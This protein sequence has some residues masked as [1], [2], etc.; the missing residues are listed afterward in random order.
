MAIVGEANILVKAITTG[1][2]ADLKRQL[3]GMSG[4]I[5]A[6]GRRSGESLGQAFSRGFRQS[7]ASNV[8]TQL[9]NGIRA[10]VPDAE[11]ARLQ[12]RSLVRVGY[13][14]STAL[15]TIIGGL[16]AL[17]GGLI[18]LVGAIGRAL[19]AVAGLASAFIQMRV[20]IGFAQFAL[21]GIGQ[22]VS[23]ATKQNQGLGK[24]IAEINE[25]FQQLQFQAEEAALSEGRAALNLEKALENLRRTADLPPNSAARREAKLAYEEAELAYRKAKDRTQDL[26]AEVAKGPQA[27]NQAGGADPYAGLTESQKA[28]A[29]FLVGLRPKL[30][31]LREAVASGFLPALQTQI[32]ELV[33]FYF[34]DLEGQLEKLGIALGQGSGN[35]FDNFLEESTKAEVDLFFE[36]LNKNIPLIGEI[37]GELGEVLLK[38]FNDADGIGTQFLTFVRDTLVEWNEQ[39]DRNGLGGFF[40]DAYDTG[41]RLFGI[42]GNIF[43][44]LGDFFEILDRSGALDTILKFF[45]TTTGGFADL[46]DD[47]GTV[48]IEGMKLG[49]TFAGMANNFAPV[50]GFLGDI[51]KL[52]FELG[53]NPAVS[54]AFE[55]LRDPENAANWESIFTAMVEAGP[56]LSDLLVTI[57]EIL[58]GFADSEAP[59]AFF[60]T[61]NMLIRPL[62]DFFKDPA[63]KE[64]VDTIG[65]I[66]AQVTA[67]TFV[68]GG[69]QF[70]LKVML[71]NVAVLA[72]GIGKFF[73]FFFKGKKDVSG[74]TKLLNGIKSIFTTIILKVWYFME[75][76]VKVFGK[77][78]G[79]IGKL[80]TGLMGWLG[81]IGLALRAAFAANPIGLIITA[82][83]L[84]IA[85]LTWFFTKTEVGKEIWGNFMSWLKD[86]WDGLVDKFNMVADFFKDLFDDP[87]GTIKNLWV[88]FMNF[89]IG[90][91]EGFI[92]FFIDGLNGLIGKANEG[93]GFLGELVGKELSIGYIGKVS[94]PRIPALAT[95]GVV[96]PS[97]GG[98]L[99]RI[100]EAGRP[101]RVE[102]L[103]ANGLSKRDYAMIGAIRGA[104]GVNIVVNPSPGMDERE[105]AAAVSRRIAY[106]IKKGAI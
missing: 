106:E 53:A 52:F 73:G 105:L 18:T 100:A 38:V 81:R 101:E 79:F 68:L 64:F 32:Q 1:F 97:A 56:A 85:A 66:F 23:A 48:S 2:D 35:I 5:G 28:F 84:A 59:T 74:F 65:K 104:G 43:N 58:A 86:L 7:G 77:V 36:N 45:E 17:V 19:P 6:A 93:L 98:T 30:D 102:P 88:A 34:P 33:D 8:F 96:S 95:G 60:D 80:F 83:G 29:Q 40:Q 75:G 25:E 15:G 21:K 72:G 13:T 103:D 78:F 20:A 31:T 22:A 91:A 39:L 3:Q 50:M 55:R 63:N 67:F 44:G 24:S 12:F 76:V 41:S 89:L 70:F 16:G 61:I 37:F 57:G 42:V 11:A 69:V 14:V 87:I 90:K 47:S 82:I 4:S 54:E 62:A 27:L 71:G 51:F 46:I 10:M 92:N 9:S 49:D 99:A 94:L 26:N